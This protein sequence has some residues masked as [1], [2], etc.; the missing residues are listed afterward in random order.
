VGNAMSTRHGLSVF[1]GMT[2]L[3]GAAHGAPPADI[4]AYV[5]RTLETFDAPGFSLAIVENGKTVHAKG[6]GLRQLGDKARAD[7]HTLF[8]I[9]SCTKA[10][11]SAGLAILV[12]EGK[13]AWDDK[14]ADVLPGFRMHDPYTTAHMTVRDL[15]VHNSGLGLGAGDL[16]WLGGTDYSRRGLMERLRY[17]EPARS[18]RDGYAYDNVLYVVAGVLIEH[19]SGMSWEAFTEKR[20]LAPLGMKDSTVP[21]DK[22]L[23]ARN[24]AA[25]HARLKGELRGLGPNEVLPDRST[26]AE[27]PNAAPA[28]SIQA[29]AADIAEWMKVQLARGALPNGKRLYSEQQ[30][31]EMWTPRTIE[32][33]DR[34]PPILDARKPNFNLYA[35]GWSVE[36]YRGHKIVN[37]TGGV[38]G[39]A[40]WVLL[41]PEKN[42]GIAAMVNSE[43]GAAR[44][45]VVYHL[46]DHYLGLSQE[47]WIGNY[48][49]A[50]D[51]I[52]AGGL[53][54]LKQLPPEPGAGPGAK[55]GPSLAL[56]KYAGAYEDPW[57]GTA[58]I[59]VDGPALHLQL[60]HTPAL[61]SRL[62]HVRFDTFR[63]RFAD[64]NIEDA[65]VTFAL[66]PDGTIARVTLQPV[67]PL[68]DFSFNYKDLLFT[69]V[70]RK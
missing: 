63:T 24:R 51:Q 29:S 65:Y 31:A 40:A 59:K 18:F 20:I 23:K 44:R 26:V 11:V 1:A 16:L 10:F 54:A 35:L 68:A 52:M 45:A 39:G 15:L 43:D 67:S 21:F 49:K 25:L 62:E 47:D 27:S 12:D 34:Y 36:D 7:A 66:N 2:M 22:A 30:A 37:H 42:V 17:I 4:D 64:R 57:Y 53:E 3:A 58:T 48:R 70:P 33:P 61:R 69:P 32:P 56:E 13:L 60:D 6:Y 38:F 9:G 19:L 55:V 8:P 50:V 14:V 5:A 46:A 28:G 41:I